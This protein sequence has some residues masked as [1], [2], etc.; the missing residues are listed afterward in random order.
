MLTSCVDDESEVG[1]NLQNPGDKAAVF[2]DS[3]TTLYTYTYQQYD[4]IYLNPVNLLLGYNVDDKLG[5]FQNNFMTE[6]GL[7]EF[8]V[9]FGENPVAD[10]M[11]LYLNYNSA[12]GDTIQTQTI[13]VYEL[14]K[15]LS[16]NDYT[17]SIHGRPMADSVIL[18][19][20]DSSKPITSFTFEPNPADTL[21][22]KI[23]LPE[24]FKNR[25]L[26]TTY[27]SSLD[28]FQMNVF[29]GFYFIAEPITDGGAI[30]YFNI[31]DSTRMELNYHNDEDTSTYTYLINNSS[32]R[33]NTFNR[34]SSTQINVLPTES[35]PDTDLVQEHFYVKFNNAFEG[36][37]DIT[38]LQTWA[39]S[40]FYTI[41][42]AVLDIYTVEPEID[43]IYYPLPKLQ[44]L[45]VNDNHERMFLNEY[46]AQSEYAKITHGELPDGFGYHIN[47]NYTLYDAIQNGDDKL[48]L[49]L[50]T[51]RES[52]KSLA[53]RMILK[54]AVNTEQP[55]K[56]RITYTK[57]N[58][59]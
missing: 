44:V 8:N 26:D 38:G 31:S 50:T 18:E 25:F 40:G 45:K 13:S 12:Y 24:D 17:N 3:S 11:I 47:I 41:N 5:S 43:S 9:S 19:Y 4:S 39:D 27:Y 22:I 46:L 56:L 37:I 49:I 21:S 59:D 15:D 35:E 2:N 28:S 20:Y 48:S 36:R 57:L 6:I 33:C 7:S 34:K 29:R 53:N 30:S 58:V 42:K 1:L 14:N 55:L 32:Y 23:V 52:N 54:G 51:D 10:N 16:L